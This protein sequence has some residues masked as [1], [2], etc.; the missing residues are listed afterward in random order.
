M[1][2]HQEGIKQVMEGKEGDRS[3]SQDN[4]PKKSVY[5]IS[6]LQRKIFSCSMTHGIH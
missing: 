2:G 6:F 5:M 4:D 3:L 1:L